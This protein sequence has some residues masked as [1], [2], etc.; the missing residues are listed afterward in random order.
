MEGALNSCSGS[1]L[2]IAL[3][4]T[5]AAGLGCRNKAL[6]DQDQIGAAA[7]EAMASLDESVDGRAAAAMLQIFQLPDQLKVPRWRRA[8]GWLKPTAYAASCWSSA[9]SACDTGVRSRQFGDCTLG[10]ATL[11]G[12]VTLTFSR[13]ALCTVVTAGDSVTRTAD[14]TLTGPYGGTLQVTSPDG[15]QMLTKTAAGFEYAVAGMR[16]VLTTAA[17]RTL[18]DVST[19][20]T[21]PL[22]V[23]GS[24]RADL[25]I[26]S[27]TLEVSHNL[28]GYKVALT[29]DHLA[30]ASSC[31]CAVSGRLTGTVEGG[32]LSGKS[33][34][35]ELT[36]CGQAEVT[37]NGESD[38]VTLDRCA[39][40]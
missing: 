12:S 26:V 21:A 20:T 8:V 32:K 25:E 37:V 13:T 11:D 28:A 4:I 30:W 5:T 3:A 17:G 22:V 9:F 36:G 15:G 40:Q 31:N 1:K 7:G 19:R 29:A 10:L 27:G 24:S 2:A 23:T 33:A 34:A 14:F 18:F 6:D 35:V 38:S 39:S 16:R